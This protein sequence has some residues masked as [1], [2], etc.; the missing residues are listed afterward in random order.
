MLSGMYR[1]NTHR[2][3]QHESVSQLRASK[4]AEYFSHLPHNVSEG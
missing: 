2:F 4:I 3:P 1:C